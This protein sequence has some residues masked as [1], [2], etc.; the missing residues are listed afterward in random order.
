MDDE[1][2]CLR[3]GK[4]CHF[5]VKGKLRRCKYLKDTPDGKTTC[6]R[7]KNRLGTILNRTPLIVCMRRG[8]LKIDYPG[9][10]YN[11]GLPIKDISKDLIK[12]KEGYNETNE[13]K[14]DKHS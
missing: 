8:K 3:C 14:K 1:D 2:K 9:C 7:Y 4:C 12:M 5:Y 13:T 11:T 10:P 6:K